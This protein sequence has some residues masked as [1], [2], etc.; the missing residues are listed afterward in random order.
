MIYIDVYE[1][2]VDLN[3]MLWALKPIVVLQS[4]KQWCICVEPQTL[5]GDVI[6]R[7]SCLSIVG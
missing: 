3:K 1:S 4:S 5:R 6:Q 2:V 7:G